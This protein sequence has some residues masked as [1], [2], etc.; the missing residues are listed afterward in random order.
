MRSLNKKADVL[1]LM[2]AVKV[3]GI[4]LVKNANFSVRKLF[5]ARAIPVVSV[6][7]TGGAL[8]ADGVK[9]NEQWGSGNKKGGK[10]DGPPDL[11][12]A[13]KK[14]NQKLG[15][16]FGKP[17]G[18]NNGPTPPNG[19]G[20]GG[21]SVSNEAVGGIAV[22][23]MFLVVAVWLATG[24]YQVDEGTRGVELRLGKYN[25]NTTTP[26]L[27]WRLPYPFEKEEIVDVERINVVEVGHRNNQKTKVKEESLMI[28]EDQNIVDVQFAVQYK[29]K[30][31][32]AEATI[33]SAV[34][35]LF[36][37]KAPNE[38]VQQAAEAA[39]RE[40]VGKSKMDFVLYEG[41]ADVSTRAKV[42][43][44]S[45]LDRYETGLVVTDLNLQN[46][47]PPEQ[48]QG[49]FDDV[50]NAKQERER[51]KNLGE[52][53]ANNILPRAKGDAARL[54]EEANGHKQKVVATAKGDAARFSSVVAEYE[55]A[56]QITRE[57][58]YLEM[59]ST[60]MQNSSKVLV[61]QKGGQNMLYLP[62]DKIMQMNAQ[63]PAAAVPSQ[64]TE[65]ITVRPQPAN[66]AEVPRRDIRDRNTR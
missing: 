20:T 34:Q 38:A 54:L 25:G 48:V 44:Q 61:D 30:P 22:I 3:A 29:L 13:L 10:N 64:V 32:A 45:I 62:L 18:S 59:M 2:R 12:E 9:L 27:H 55:K 1:E 46:A 37:N 14:L 56:P 41:R 6:N 36:N 60:V 52:A 31:I 17:K 11:D 26:G 53:E 19:S 66:N 5:G 16:L 42:L 24:F 39:M 15:N 49:A 7:N 57:R 21:P 51:N 58:M 4:A 50:V 23:A 28:T 35:F 63:A 33:N 40:V 8:G 43:M 65:T 47:Q